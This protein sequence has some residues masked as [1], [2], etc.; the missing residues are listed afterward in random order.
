MG[1]LLL[2]PAGSWLFEMVFGLAFAISLIV[3]AELLAREQDRRN[4]VDV[5]ANTATAFEVTRSP[6]EAVTQ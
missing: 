5:V 4:N 2:N 6:S 1:E 3:T